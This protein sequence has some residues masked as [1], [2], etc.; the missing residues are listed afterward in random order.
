VRGNGGG[1]GVRLNSDQLKIR[2]VGKTGER[3]FGSVVGM[4]AAIFGGKSGCLEG[5]LH[6]VQIAARH[7]D[8]IDVKLFGYHR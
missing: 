4:C 2:A 3:H 8:V 7:G 5:L 6:G 1:I